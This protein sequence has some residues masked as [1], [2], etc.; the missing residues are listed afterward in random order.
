MGTFKLKE[1]LPYTTR[2]EI[3]RIS[4]IAPAQR[5]QSEADF[6]TALAPYLVNEVIVRDDN[7]LITS[8]SGNDL[9]TGDSGFKKGAIFIEKDAVGNGLYVNTGD[10]NSAVWAISNVALTDTPV[11][12]VK[13]SGTVTNGN[14]DNVDDGNTVVI[15]TVTY[16]FKT[17]LTTD[18]DTVAYEVLIG[19]D[20]DESFDNL[21]LAING[22]AGIGTNYSLGTV[23]HPLVSAGAVASHATIITAKTYGVAGDDIALGKVGDHITVSG[24]NLENGVDGDVDIAGSIRYD[25]DFIYVCV[26]SN[27]LDG[28]TWKKSVLS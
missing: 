9:P 23:A 22:G 12:S 2:Q 15:G 25:A 17:A 27:N 8:A 14:T 20:A 11:D 10:E 6:L 1:N 26:A 7:G 19:T 16:T 28:A 18:P 4:A 21:V 3:D 24:S 13:S 5:L